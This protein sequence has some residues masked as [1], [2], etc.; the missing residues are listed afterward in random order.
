MNKSRSAFALTLV[1]LGA[2]ASG[3][4][5][6]KP[7]EPSLMSKSNDPTAW[8]EDDVKRGMTENPRANVKN[9]DLTGGWSSRARGI[10]SSLGVG[11]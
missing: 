7:S 4:S 2:L 3:C 11:N 6:T 9:S 10:E 1:V 5:Q 8:S